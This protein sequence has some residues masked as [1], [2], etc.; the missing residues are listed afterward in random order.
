MKTLALHFHT[1]IVVIF[2]QLLHILSSQKNFDIFCNREMKISNV[3]ETN[4]E[5]SQDDLRNFRMLFHER[6]VDNS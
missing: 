1:V 3:C 5:N 6:T 2:I 4:I